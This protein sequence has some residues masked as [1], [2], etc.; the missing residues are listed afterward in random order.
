M[1]N[2]K[3]VSM[4]KRVAITSLLL[5]GLTFYGGVDAHRRRLTLD[6][7]GGLNEGGSDEFD[8]SEAGG[9]RVSY[10]IQSAPTVKGVEEEVVNYGQPSEEDEEEAAAPVITKKSARKR[11]YAPELLLLDPKPRL[12]AN[13]SDPNNQP[14][15]GLEKGA[16]HYLAQ[17]GSKALIQWKVLHSA[18]EGNC[19][20]RVGHGL[21]QEEGDE[22]KFITLIPRDGSADQ[23]GSFAC[24]RDIGYEAKEFKLPNNI[25]CDSC[26]LQFEFTTQNG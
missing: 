13:L 12:L 3:K 6:E 5:L 7:P 15:G 19:T 1:E 18:P 2:Y 11:V 24:G 9:G 26:T 14:C 16:V 10:K 20:L 25:T 22:N 17:P 21:D 8:D 4:K 23:H